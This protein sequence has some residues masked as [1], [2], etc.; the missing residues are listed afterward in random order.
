M[1]LLNVSVRTDILDLD[2]KL[3]MILALL[4]HV[5]MEELALQREQQLM[6]LNAD[7]FPGLLDGFVP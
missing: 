6:S 2:A 4:V 5:A 1:E 3:E 7:V